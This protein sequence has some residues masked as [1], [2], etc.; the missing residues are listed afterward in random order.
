MKL[1]VNF[2]A[3]TKIVVCFLFLAFPLIANAGLVNNA[4]TLTGEDSLCVSMALLDSLGSPTAVD[5]TTDWMKIIIFKADGDS[6]FADSMM[7]DEGD[8]EVEI[9]KLGASGTDFNQVFTYSVSIADIDGTATG[10]L[11]ARNGTYRYAI[12]CRDSSLKLF[13]PYFGEFQLVSTGTDLSPTTALTDAAALTFTVANEVNSN[14]RYVG[15]DAITDNGDGRLEVNVEEWRDVAP[16]ALT[17]D[18]GVVAD[19]DSATTGGGAGSVNAL[20]LASVNWASTGGDSVLQSLDYTNNTHGVLREGLAGVDADTGIAGIKTKLTTIAGYTDDIGIAGAGLTAADDA[21]IT[22]IADVPTVAEL[23][24]RT[25]PS[26]NYFD[27]TTDPVAVVTRVDSVGHGATHAIAGHLVDTNN[28]ARDATKNDYK[29]T[30]FSTFDPTTDPVAVVTRVD[31]LGHGATHAIAGHL[32]DTNNIARDATKND[33]KATGFST[34]DPTSDPVAVVTRVDSVGHG[35]THAIA[36]HLVD[37]NNIA[38]DATKNDYKATG[39]S[40]FDPTT[41]PVA[42]VTRVDSVGHGG[43][44]AIG[45]HLT[46]TNLV[47]TE[48]DLGLPTNFSSLKINADGGVYLDTSTAANDNVMGG[49]ELK[50]AIVGGTGAA[51]PTTATGVVIASGTYSSVI[52][53]TTLEVSNPV[54]VDNILTGTIDSSDYSS[55]GRSFHRNAPWQADTAGSPAPSWEGNETKFGFWNASRQAATGTNCGS[56]TQ[57]DSI[58]VLD[59]SG[60]DTPI[61]FISVSAADAAGNVWSDKSNGDGWVLLNLAPLTEYT[62]SAFS[63]A[64]IFSQTVRTMSDDGFDTDTVFGYDWIIPAPSTDGYKR[65]WGREYINDDSTA[66]PAA[67]VMVSAVLSY[68]TDPGNGIPTDTLNDNNLGR[69][70][71]VLT[72][73]DANGFWQLDV[74][75]NTIITPAN[76]FWQVTAHGRWSQGYRFT[77]T[78]TERLS[79]LTGF[80]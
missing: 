8:P 29:A 21:M 68:R 26:A 64:Y 74:P 48:S 41:D 44:H 42:V 54:S 13:T 76:S 34:F 1:H 31:T 7:I 66:G 73:T 9:W 45:L 22:A 67:G 2:K 63:G 49:R 40:T 55:T 4:G 28:I 46:D 56:G 27:P 53:G 14:V 80:R 15:G 78:T 79:S 32:V 51:I 43:T 5:S 37:T 18:G 19:L 65:I 52:I 25:L 3:A 23:E 35:G 72:R 69:Q 33:Y 10:T 47:A 60:V 77:T 70:V 17:S 59:T 36:G 6:V 71:R 11:A 75:I 62:F 16:L 50:Q 24:A 20:E 38:R 58:L 61:P 12:Y 39:F 57:I 30:G